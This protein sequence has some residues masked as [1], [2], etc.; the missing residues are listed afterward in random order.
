VDRQLNDLSLKIRKQTLE[1]QAEL[2]AMKS[3]LVNETFQ[4]IREHLDSIHNDLKGHH[5]ELQSYLDHQVIPKLSQSVAEQH[6]LIDDKM[7]ALLAEESAAMKSLLQQISL[8]Q[9][10]QD[11]TE[12]ASFAP[13]PS[14]ETT[15]ASPNKLKDDLD[16]YH[17]ELKMRG[18]PG[19]I[20]KRQEGY[21]DLLAEK[22]GDL[23]EKAILDVGG[24]S[25]IFVELLQETGAAAESI[26]L[27]AV[28]VGAGREMGRSVRV[29]SL[30]DDL[31]AREENS[32]HAITAFQ[33]VEHLPEAELKNFLEQ[34]HRVLQ[35][36][37]L[38][39][40]E[41]LNPRSIAAYR[42][43]FMDLTHAHFLQPETLEHLA[44]NAGFQDNEIHETSQPP[45]WERLRE[46]VGDEAMQENI[47]RLNAFLYG[48]MEYYL[49]GY[50]R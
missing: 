24:G 18:D 2:V 1:T 33:V 32:L 21:R 15:A 31:A 27:N 17:F 45:D 46:D 13:A 23:K 43:Y 26:D 7:A 19:S 14:S 38:I 6:K 35:S 44:Q 8:P 4:L 41:T 20:R 48:P 28:A 47:K 29:A 16:Y 42:W 3:E 37:G 49:L 34:A 9:A 40:L 12:A 25:G 11:N 10:S 5:T 39:L 50:K 36:G 22:L 30:H